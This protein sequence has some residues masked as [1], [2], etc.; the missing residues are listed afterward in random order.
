MDAPA[1]GLTDA[2]NWA[3]ALGNSLGIAL[4]TLWAHKLRSILTVL[5]IVIG[6]AAV[7]LIGATLEVVRGIGGEEHGSDNRRGH[8]HH[9]PGGICRQPQPQ[10]AFGSSCAKIPKFTA[11]KRRRWPRA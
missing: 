4:R 3:E 2:P 8:I 7:V 10:R 1:K 6:I 9:C 11:G 5:G